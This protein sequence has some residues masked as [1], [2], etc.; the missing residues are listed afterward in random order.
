MQNTLSIFYLIIM[1]LSLCTDYNI[2]YCVIHNITDCEF[3]CIV[4]WSLDI[5]FQ[6]STFA[7]MNQTSIC[8]CSC[9]IY[10]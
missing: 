7:N 10:C 4:T 1:M 5:V 9:V 6:G 3:N 8:T 2:H